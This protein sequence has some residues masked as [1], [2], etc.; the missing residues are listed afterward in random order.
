MSLVSLI[1]LWELLNDLSK[2]F[3]VLANSFK[4]VHSVI[5][6]LDVVI[7]MLF[8]D[9]LHIHV[10]RVALLC[11]V[12]QNGLFAVLVSARL[13]ETFQV[14]HCHQD[15]RQLSDFLELFGAGLF[16]ISLDLLLLLVDLL[17]LGVQLRN[18]IVE[19]HDLRVHVLLIF[20]HSV[21]D[22]CQS[23]LFQLEVSFEIRMSFC[24]SKITR[25]NVGDLGVFI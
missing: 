6:A 14:V 16:L 8:F 11:H 12:V 1:E 5:L 15:A 9:T 4:L 10:L 3:D 23:R 2:I 24:E 22:I 25:E 17:K 19:L 20:H 13:A 18:V 21:L 7:E